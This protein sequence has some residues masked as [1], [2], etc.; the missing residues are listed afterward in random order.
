MVERLLRSMGSSNAVQEELGDPLE[1]LAAIEAEIQRRTWQEHPEIW[2]KEKLNNNIWSKQ[3]EILE[4]IRDN[5][6]TLVKSCHAIGKSFISARVACWWLSV[7][8]PGTAFVVTSAPSGPQIKAILWREIGR[9][10]MQGRLNG[11]VNQTEWY[12]TVDGKEELVAFGRK[13]QDEDMASF[14]GI[15]ARR[16]LVIFDESNGIRGVLHEAASSLTANDDSKMLQIGNPDFPEGEFY[17]NSK[18]GSGWHVISVD[19]FSSPNFTGEKLPVEISSQLIGRTYVEEKR[20]RWAPQWRWSEDGKTCNPPEGVRR[21]DTSP[22][23][24]SK[25]LGEFP[26]IS[27]VNG[28]IPLSWINA[29]QL[30]D[31]SSTMKDGTN[32]LGVDPGAGGDETAVCQK[33][34]QVYRIIRTDQDPNTMATCGKILDDLDRTGAT[35]VRIDQIGIGYGILQRGLELGRPFVGINV[36]M[37]AED[38]ESSS[39]ERFANMKCQLYWHLRG[40]FERGEIDIDSDDVDLASELCTIRY[41]RMSNGRLKISDKHKDDKGKT[42]MSPNRAEAL[43]L[44]SAP[45]RLT[46]G[47]REVEVMWG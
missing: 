20:R 17:E 22:M 43:M 45:K 34:G 19:A 3:R 39:D 32:E 7:W 10:F 25:I 18:P 16:V 6:K 36:G 14:Q 8:P 4:S 33:R 11:R 13:P 15:H 40:L 31:L 44:A 47:A 42:I 41:E 30:R 37:G 27:S 21:E 24:Q 2:V 38:D 28:L 12:Q 23:W 9:A 29:A 35:V 5:R 1:A 46:R 26:E